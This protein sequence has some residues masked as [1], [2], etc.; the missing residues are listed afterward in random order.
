MILEFTLSI[1]VFPG[2]V[3][4]TALALFSEWFIRKVVARMQNRMGP[5]YVGPFGILQPLADIMKLMIAKEEIVQR[6]SIQVVARIFASL[7]L[8]ALIAS[9]LL[10]PISPFRLISDFDFLIY[11]YLCCLIVPLSIIFIGLAAPNPFTE[12]GVSRLLTMT[13]LVEPSYFTAFIIPIVLATQIYG[14][15]LPASYSIYSTSIV[16]WRLWLNP[17]TAPAMILGLF[18]ALVAMQA[19]FMIQPFNIP[20]AEQEIIAGFETELS[21]PI[22]GLMRLLH[23]MDIA[24]TTLFIVYVFLGGPYPFKHLTVYGILTLVAKYVAILFI[25]TLMKAVFGRLR[26]D[27]ALGILFKYSFIPALAG[28]VYMVLF[29]TLLPPS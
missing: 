20:E 9:L 24:V 19:K 21:G 12:T 3:F 11:F 23:D 26:I 25:V 7:G 1:L 17:L 28:V 4:A 15:I 18:A 6:Y 16:A 13:L 5:S 10:L 29:L 14:E 2:L 8:G 27:Q 22:L